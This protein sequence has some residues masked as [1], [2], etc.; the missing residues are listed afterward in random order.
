MILKSIWQKNKT[1]TFK[2]FENNKSDNPAKVI[3]RRFP[4]SDETFPYAN[5]QNVLDSEIVKSFDNTQKAKEKLIEYIINSMVNNI[6]AGRVNY[7]LFLKECV[8]KFEDLI[9]EDKEIKST[10]DFLRLPTQAVHI[11]A[12]ELYDYAKLEDTFTTEQ[13]KILE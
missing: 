9:Y 8:D 6:T 4:L 13:K 10:D 1:Y 11:I 7:E 12:K 5:Q 3:F 2:A